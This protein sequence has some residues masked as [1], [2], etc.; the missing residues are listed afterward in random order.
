MFVKIR[1]RVQREK[2]VQICSNWCSTH[3]LLL[4][5]SYRWVNNF[6]FRWAAQ[7][8]IA[9]WWGQKRKGNVA[10]LW[11][12]MA[13]SSLCP[14]PCC[15]AVICARQHC[16]ST[17]ITSIAVDSPILCTSSFLQISHHSK[18]DGPH[19][20]KAGETVRWSLQVGWRYFK[21]ASKVKYCG[22]ITICAFN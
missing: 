5:W 4:H 17:A 18:W 7:N 3:H 15:C 11:F 12:C 14:S 2:Q 19:T 10:T 22:S 16:G 8:C 13:V 6:K 1:I 20:A 21:R 9:S